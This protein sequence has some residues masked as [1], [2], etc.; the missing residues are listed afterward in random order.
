[1]QLK[2][3][4]S[5]DTP[6]ARHGSANINISCHYTSIHKYT[7]SQLSGAVEYTDCF[8]AEELRPP[9]NECPAYDTKQTNGEVLV[10]LEL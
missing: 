8:S 9:H 6:E 1:M 7:I 3:P 5:D 4:S 10:M 2:E